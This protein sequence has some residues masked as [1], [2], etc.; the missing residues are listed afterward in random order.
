MALANSKNFLPRYSLILRVK[1]PLT[2]A[3]EHK[4][5]VKGTWGRQK[6]EQI[7]WPSDFRPFRLTFRCPHPLD[8]AFTRL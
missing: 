1:K 3:I 6:F 5:F 7:D 4:V 2:V 8:G